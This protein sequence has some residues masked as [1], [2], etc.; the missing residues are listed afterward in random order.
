M[1]VQSAGTQKLPKFTRNPNLG[2]KCISANVALSAHE[3]LDFIED[4]AI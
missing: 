1:T 3:P 2:T 4:E